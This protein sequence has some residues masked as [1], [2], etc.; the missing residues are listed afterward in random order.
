MTFINYQI[1]NYAGNP[2]FHTNNMKCLRNDLGE[3]ERENYKRYVM[4]SDQN[5]LEIMKYNNDM[6]QNEDDG[7]DWKNCKEY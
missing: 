3:R 6:D 7:Y 4:E 5:S 1:Y 2:E